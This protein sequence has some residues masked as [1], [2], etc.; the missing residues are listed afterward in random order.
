MHPFT[1]IFVFFHLKF[2]SPVSEFCASQK[3]HQVVPFSRHFC[4]SCFVYFL[5]SCL[6]PFYMPLLDM[7]NGCSIS[8]HGNRNKGYLPYS[9]SH[10]QPCISLSF[11]LISLLNITNFRHFLGHST[12]T[13]ASWHWGLGSHPGIYFV[14]IWRFLRSITKKYEWRRHQSWVTLECPFM[15]VLPAALWEPKDMVTHLQDNKWFFVLLLPH[16]HQICAWS[17]V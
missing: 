2:I 1:P 10:F 15:C 12:P 14:K 13:R 11:N 4:W 5:Y 7:K 16:S 9:S 8:P 6:I 3:P 17:Y